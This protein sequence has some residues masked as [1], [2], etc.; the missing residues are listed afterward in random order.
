V[1]GQQEGNLQANAFEVLKAFERATRG[2]ATPLL[3][4]QL[5]DVIQM[6]EDEAKAAFHYLKGKGLIET[7][8]GA[9]YA[10]R[11]SAAGHD[12]IREAETTPDK[13]SRAFPN[14]L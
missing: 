3:L 1:A 4:E 9:D 5:Y 2:S 6:T 12:A 7:N 8:F 11:V 13:A 14:D 10:A